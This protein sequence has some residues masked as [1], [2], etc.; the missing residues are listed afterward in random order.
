MDAFRI[1]TLARE[2][3]VPLIHHFLS[4]ESTWARGIPL[5]TV[6]RALQNSLCF[7]GF[8]GSQQVAFARVISDYSTFANL[9]DVF[10]LNEHRGHGFGKAMVAAVLAHEKLQGIRRFTLATSNAHNLYAP[11]G[12]TPPLKP[13]T[14]MERYFPGIYLT[15]P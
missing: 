9:V 1:S 7:G 6:A 14:L 8:L 10:V 2:L 11:F 15:K 12:F 5:E 3:N 13:E 4:Q